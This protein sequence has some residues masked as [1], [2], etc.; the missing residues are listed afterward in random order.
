MR[1][2]GTYRLILVLALAMGSFMPATATGH[3]LTVREDFGSTE[4]DGA[5]WA[6]Y[7]LAIGFAGLVTLGGGCNSNS[8]V[9]NPAV[10]HPRVCAVNRAERRESRAQ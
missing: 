2:R 9:E 1:F 10:P 7:A 5:R 3:S 4:I 8:E 6:G